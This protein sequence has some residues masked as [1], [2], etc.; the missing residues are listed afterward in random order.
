MNCL[1]KDCFS[2]KNGFSK[3][4][5][6]MIFC[7]IIPK[8]PDRLMSCAYKSQMSGEYQLPMVGQGHLEL[9]TVWDRKSYLVTPCV[10]VFCFVNKMY[11]SISN[12]FSFILLSNSSLVIY[13]KICF[14]ISNGNWYS[15]FCITEA[16]RFTLFGC[17]EGYFET[18]IVNKKL[19]TA[20]QNGHF[21]T[22]S[23]K[24]YPV[25]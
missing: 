25:P 10:G 14:L 21:C 7:L 16:K 6:F 5:P 24:P 11:F 18:K 1:F 3:S 9:R 8:P 20:Y 17:S 4:Q 13:W 12:I 15:D 23:T 2:G 22:S 19:E